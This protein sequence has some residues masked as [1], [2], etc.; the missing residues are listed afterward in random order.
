MNDKNSEYEANYR[1]A[2]S[3]L[4]L[5]IKEQA[6]DCLDRAYAQVPNDKKSGSNTVYLDI[7]DTLAILSFERGEKEKVGKL[8]G[9]GL[10]IKKNHADLLFMRSLLLMDERRYDEMLESIIHYYLSITDDDVALYNYKYV[11]EGALREVHDN[12]FPT[13]YRN[14]FQHEH[15]REIIFNLAKTT[16]NQWLIKACELMASIDKTRSNLEN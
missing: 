8:I 12:L 11:H 6:L 4:K 2:L 7:L 14:A 16:Q 10:S 1:S 15:I 9:E 5:G 13:A 3:F